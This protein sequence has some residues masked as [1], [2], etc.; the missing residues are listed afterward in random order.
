MDPW[1][2]V[3]MRMRVFGRTGWEVSEIGYGAWQIGGSM[4]G[5]VSVQ[6]AK[7]ALNAALDSGIDFFDTALVYGSGASEVLVGQVIRERK[8]REDVRVATKVPP[9]NG[10]WPARKNA[11]L[12]DVFPA[13][14][15][16]EC[17]EKSR[18]NLDVGPIDLLQLHVWTD[19]W[20]ND[21]E[22]SDAMLDLRQKGKVLA[23]G[24]SIN[25]HDPNDAVQVTV[26]DKV[27]SLQ[28]I[29]NIFDQSPE[30]NLFA[31]ARAKNV[32]VIVRVPL[33]EGSLG[34]TLRNDT[35]FEAGDWRARYFGGVR[36]RETVKRVEKLRPIL[37][38]V[39]QTLAQ[40]ALRYCLSNDA[41]STVIVGS[42]NPD[43]VRDNALVSDMGPLDEETLEELRRHAWQRNFYTW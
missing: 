17:V 39:D 18:T 30:E 36:L 40:G 21:N 27:D 7:A 10:E 41:V 32:A 16:Y 29:Y 42:S 9:M 33:D 3:G 22:W 38:R 23:C 8:V 28:L 24:V 15:I 19:S 12:R 4:W 31:A 35:K 14:W 5:S 25:D 37:E 26:S 20:A 34:G 43:H 2:E 13:R 11:K 6:R 1:A